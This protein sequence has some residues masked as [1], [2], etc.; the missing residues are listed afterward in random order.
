MLEHPISIALHLRSF[1][2]NVLSKMLQNVTIELNT[3]SPTLSD[4]SLLPFVK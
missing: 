3:D 1:V 2:Q 4:E